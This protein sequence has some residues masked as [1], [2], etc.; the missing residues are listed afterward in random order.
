MA[1]TVKEFVAKHGFT[2]TP[3]GERMEVDLKAVVAS[4]E[5]RASAAAYRAALDVIPEDDAGHIHSSIAFY[6]S[7]EQKE[8]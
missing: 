1:L 5:A 3:A 8:I 4:A 6:E 7:K 2:G